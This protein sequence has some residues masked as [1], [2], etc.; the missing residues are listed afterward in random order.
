MRPV[1]HVRRHP[2]HCGAPLMTRD[3][4]V[5]LSQ[6]REALP[7]PMHS[8][9]SIAPPAKRGSD[10]ELELRSGIDH[11]ANRLGVHVEVLEPQ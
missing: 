7:A 2:D 9:R 8:P 3:P 4:T 10:L 5:R 11:G 1:A 6:P